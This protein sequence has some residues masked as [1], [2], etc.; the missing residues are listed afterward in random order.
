MAVGIAGMPCSWAGLFLCLAARQ[1]RRRARWRGA[2][3]PCWAVVKSVRYQEGAAAENGDQRP[4]IVHRGHALL[5]RPG[6][7]IRGAPAVPGESSLRRFRGRSSP[8][9]FDR[10]Q[11]GSGFCG[12]RARTHWCVFAALGCLCTAAGAGPCC[13]MV[14]D[15]WRSWPPTVWRPP[16]LAGSTVCALIGLI[17][18]A[19]AY[20]CV[21]A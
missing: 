12:R 19:C 5:H 13:W 15:S 21:G 2:V 1:Y 14:P 4:Q 9:L 3:P 17:C 18:G 11:Q 10:G 8:I 20:A 6:Q 16:N 7:G